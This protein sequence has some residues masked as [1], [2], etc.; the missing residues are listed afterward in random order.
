MRRIVFV[1]LLMA[2]ASCQ[3]GEPDIAARRAAADKAQ[4][5][6]CRSFGA[7]PGSN[8]YVQCRTTLY[9]QARDED[10]QRRRMA[11]AYLLNRKGSQPA[12][13]YQMQTFK[14]TNCTSMRNGV[15]VNTTCY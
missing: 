6:Q 3:T 4:D 1:G 7:K 14:P 13:P 10:Q 5:A 12:A 11:A 8:A 2:L 15:M 9:A